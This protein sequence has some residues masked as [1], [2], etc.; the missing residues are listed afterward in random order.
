M[1]E[2][3]EVFKYLPVEAATDDSSVI[4]WTTAENMR[5]LSRKYLNTN[6]YFCA[7]LQP[8]K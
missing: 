8:E 7:Y 3:V 4:K 2:A 1:I 6:N 5:E